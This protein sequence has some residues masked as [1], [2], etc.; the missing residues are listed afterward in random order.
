M[1]KTQGSGNSKIYKAD[2]KPLPNV[3]NDVTGWTDA[4]MGN[5]KANEEA[6]ETQM[7]KDTESE[8]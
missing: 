1:P 7:Q 4:Q 6:G 3:T 2:P 8:D 5:T